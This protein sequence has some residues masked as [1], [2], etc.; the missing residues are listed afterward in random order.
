MSDHPVV[1]A[2]KH[3][4]RSA[5]EEAWDESMDETHDG[6]HKQ[7]NGEAE[8]HPLMFEIAL[9]DRTGMIQKPTLKHSAFPQ[10]AKIILAESSKLL[11]NYPVETTCYGI[12]FDGAS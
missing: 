1:K 8:R 5:F 12:L 7:S 10:R 3:P 2:R 4:A 9:S 6:G 11:P